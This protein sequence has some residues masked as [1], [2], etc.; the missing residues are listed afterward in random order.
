MTVY[1]DFNCNIDVNY[2]IIYLTYVSATVVFSSYTGCF[3]NWE[4]KHMYM[5]ASVYLHIVTDYIFNI[6]GRNAF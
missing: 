6:L 4:S 1:M 3:S 5:H 2:N